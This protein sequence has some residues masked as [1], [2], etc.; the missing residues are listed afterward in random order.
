MYS[1]ASGSKE[2]VYILT[3]GFGSS[4]PKL[5]P[6][7]EETTNLNKPDEIVD[8]D[9]DGSPFCPAANIPVPMFLMMTA[10]GST[11]GHDDGDGWQVDVDVQ[12]PFFGRLVRYQG[13][14]YPSS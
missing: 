14:V 8:T 12:A 13:D 1:C 6:S 2:H 7:D 5:V 11:L 4:F 3:P 9:P 10:D